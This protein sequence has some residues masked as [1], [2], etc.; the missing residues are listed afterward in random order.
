MPLIGVGR[1][2]IPKETGATHRITV[3]KTGGRHRFAIDGKLIIDRTE[4]EILGPP[5]GAGKIGLRHMTPTEAYYDNLRVY[6]M[7]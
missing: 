6:R 1:D 2:P 4:P 3:V 7:K 5:H